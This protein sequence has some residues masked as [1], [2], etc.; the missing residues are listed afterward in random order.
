MHRQPSRTRH[1]GSSTVQ[2]SVWPPSPAHPHLWSRGPASGRRV[3]HHAWGLPSN[4]SHG[5]PVT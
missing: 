4:L 5:H 1:D 3:P 2:G